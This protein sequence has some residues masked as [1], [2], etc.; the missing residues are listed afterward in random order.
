MATECWIWIKLRGEGVYGEEHIMTQHWAE[1]IK[2]ND[3]N[4][5]ADENT[6]L[7]VNMKPRK[8][9]VYDRK[10]NAQGIWNMLCNIW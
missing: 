5:A 7:K 10:H 3:E 2:D 9:G 6:G 1:E 4:T 8:P